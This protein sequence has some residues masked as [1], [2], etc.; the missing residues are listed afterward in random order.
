MKR[1]M[2]FSFSEQQRRIEY[3]ASDEAKLLQ[4]EVN[5]FRISEWQYDM[6]VL[7]FVAEVLF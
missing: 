6:T 4:D 1:T 3:Q 2:D 7:W 5:N